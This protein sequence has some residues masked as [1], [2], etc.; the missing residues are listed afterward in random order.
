MKPLLIALS[1]L[2]FSGKSTLAKELAISLDFPVISYD[3][4][5]YAKH[6]NTVPPGTPP[7]EEFDIVQ[8]I[9]R[10]HVTDKL[11]AGESF[12]YDDLGLQ[13]EERESIRK[14]A[15]KANARYVLLFLDTPLDTIEQ[16]RKEN[17]QSNVR[18]HIKD[19]KMALNISLLEK[20]DSDEQ[21]IIVRPEMSL[22][23]IITTTRS[24]RVPIAPSK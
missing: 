1:G 19:E 13:K 12:I 17:S 14:I 18:S 22:D 23:H 4:D 5:I 6:K 15:E 7:A 24:L 8:A 16:R 3:H 11:V 21:A 9:A 10:Q 2:P 20:P